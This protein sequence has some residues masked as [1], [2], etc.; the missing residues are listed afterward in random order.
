MTNLTPHLHPRNLTSYPRVM[1]PEPET[2]STKTPPRTTKLSQSRHRAKIREQPHS[3][4]AS[5]RE[6]TK[7]RSLLFQVLRRSG[8]VFQRTSHQRG[9]VM[10]Y[11]PEPKLTCGIP[12]HPGQI[13]RC[14]SFIGGDWSCPKSMGNLRCLWRSRQSGRLNRSVQQCPTALPNKSPPTSR[15]PRKLGLCISWQVQTLGRR[16]RPRHMY[17]RLSSGLRTLSKRRQ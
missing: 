3:P 8:Q 14:R 7:V 10:P 9:Y 13:R 5:S 2:K 11:Q 15:H 4:Q 6:K 17:Q 1:K 12:T 16:S